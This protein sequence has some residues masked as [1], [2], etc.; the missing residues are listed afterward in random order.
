MTVLQA[1]I[2]GTIQGLTEF[3]PVSSSGHLVLV[4]EFLDVQ[5]ANNLSFDVFVHFGTLI[6][7][8]F[9]FWKDI[10]Q[11]VNSMLKSLRLTNFKEEYSKNEHL[12]L[13]V[14][15]IVGSVPAGVIGLMFRDI[16]KD[17]FTEPKLVGVNLALTGLILFFTR[18]SR[19]K[20][21]KQIGI[22]RK[23]TRLNSSHLA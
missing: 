4:Q 5:S 6:S 9:Y 17:T 10:V 14:A 2:L 18:L 21:G 15:I 1:I 23:S 8:L 11:I 12:R 3:L 19:P 13:G 7:V 20:E 16:I 22:D